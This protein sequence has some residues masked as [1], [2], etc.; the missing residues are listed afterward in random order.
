MGCPRSHNRQVSDLDS[1]GWIQTQESGP[2]AGDNPVTMVC[3]ALSLGLVASEDQ[4]GG[5]AADATVSI[6]GIV[7]MII[8]FY[9]NDIPE[10]VP[11]SARL[12]WFPPGTLFEPQLHLDSLPFEPRSGPSGSPVDL[13]LGLSTF[14][15]DLGETLLI[16]FR[17]ECDASF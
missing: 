5:S 4:S 9:S 3:G 7:I 16:I 8:S 10:H 15:N 17:D 1:R 6:I 2:R 13:G 11:S 14:T 12:Q